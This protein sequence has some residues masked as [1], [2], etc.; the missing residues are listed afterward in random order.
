MTQKIT[1][2]MDSNNSFHIADGRNIND[3]NPKELLLYAATDC[4]SKTLISLLKTRISEIKVM[5]LTI[6]GTLSTPTVVAESQFTNF[7][8]IYHVECHTLKDQLD[9]SR[10][11]NL[12]H[13]KYCGLLQMLRKIAPLS[14]ETAIV[15]T[16]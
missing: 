13:D 8:V 1:L 2:S 9:I 11:V 16:D 5:E 14:H 6:E 12:A 3:L 10:A 7:N 4:L 15:T